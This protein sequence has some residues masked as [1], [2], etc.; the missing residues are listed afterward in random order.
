[1]GCKEGWGEYCLP[2]FFLIVV[3]RKNECF[4]SFLAFASMEVPSMYMI[5]VFH[6]LTDDQ[7]DLCKYIGSV[8][9]DLIRYESLKG[10]ERWSFILAK[11]HKADICLTFFFYGPKTIDMIHRRK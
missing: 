3:Y 7:H 1:M 6:L 9:F 4:V 5:H 10:H 8:S 2:S 11:I